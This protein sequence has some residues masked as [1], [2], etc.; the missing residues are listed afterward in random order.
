M[1]QLTP[2]TNDRRPTQRRWWHP[3]IG[4]A[5]GRLGFAPYGEPS[6]EANRVVYREPLRAVRRAI[7]AAI[8]S[9][10]LRAVAHK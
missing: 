3:W 2:K 5:E 10:D 4:F 7:A 6:V 9:G 1:S 8:R